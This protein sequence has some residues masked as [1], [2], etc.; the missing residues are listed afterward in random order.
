MDVLTLIN[1]P[2]TPTHTHAQTGALQNGSSVV[3]LSI[4]N[5]V[6]ENLSL[7]VVVALPLP[8]TLTFPGGL[9][10]PEI[11]A[12]KCPKNVSLPL[13]YQPGVPRT[14]VELDRAQYCGYEFPEVPAAGGQQKEVVHCPVWPGGWPADTYH[15]LQCEGVAGWQNYTCPKNEVLNTACAPPNAQAAHA[16]AQ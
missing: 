12:L 13:L 6:I 5:L 14:D 10:S 4:G 16:K 1:H 2:H 11:H 9:P 7:P 15:T 8:R 3:G